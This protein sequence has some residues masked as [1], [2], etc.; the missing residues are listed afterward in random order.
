M[1]LIPVSSLVPAFLGTDGCAMALLG[2]VSLWEKGGASEPVA[3]RS[4]VDTTGG[5]RSA[6]L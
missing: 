2:R 6:E 1:A 5:G 4:I 3:D